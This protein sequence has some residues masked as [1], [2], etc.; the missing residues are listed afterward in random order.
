MGGFIVERYWPGVTEAD[1][2]RMAAVLSAAAGPGA[3]YLGSILIPGDEVVLFGFDADSAA[4]A[5]ARSAQAGLR[6]DRVVP[7]VF[8]DAR[9]PGPPGP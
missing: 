2:R 3:R 8:L 5:A 6:C 7:A 1:V 4:Q 9:K